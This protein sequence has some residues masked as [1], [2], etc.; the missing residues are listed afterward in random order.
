MDGGVAGVVQKALPDGGALVI[1]LDPGLIAGAAMEWKEQKIAGVWI[2][3]SGQVDWGS[4]TGDRPFS[5]L[6]DV[7][8]SELVRDLEHLR[9]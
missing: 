9:G 3:S 8:A 1:N 7:A 2:S 6:D 5:V 4:G